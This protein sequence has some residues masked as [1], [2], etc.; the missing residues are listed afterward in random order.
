MRQF[1]TF[2]KKGLHFL[3]VSILL[4]VVSPCLKAQ[5]CTDPTNVIYAFS[6][7]G[8]LYPVNVTNMATSGIINSTPLNATTGANAIGYNPVNKLMYFFQNATTSGTQF[9]SYN[10]VGNIYT[11]LATPPIAGTVNRGC[12]SYNGTDYY[13]I[14]TKGNLFYYNIPTNTWTLITSNFTDQDGNNVTSVLQNEASGDMAID[15]A[16]DLWIVVSNSSKYG[17]YKL[18]AP[19]P[20]AAVASLTV[21]RLIDPSTLT[22]D[23]TNFVG[24]AFDA[25]GDIFMATNNDL[26]LLKLNFSVLHI[27]AFSTPGMCGDLTSCNFPYNILPVTFSDFSLR[28]NNNVVTLRWQT[29]G[30]ENAKG[31]YIERSDNGVDWSERGFVSSMNNGKTSNYS[32]I[33]NIVSGGKIYYRIKLVDNTGKITYSPVKTIDT[34]ASVQAN[35]SIGP[36][37]TSDKLNIS[38]DNNETV[39][40]YNTQGL[41]M[42]NEKLHAGINSIDIH[43]LPSGVYIVSLN[44]TA[45]NTAV[46]KIVKM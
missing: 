32:Y 24:I 30:N 6:N 29:S 19:L 36:N 46:K 1:Y 39:K 40:I 45:G 25:I 15:G 3:W 12:V 10:P 43:S 44:N 7:S 13:C 26:Y 17:L 35:I 20:N 34:G 18:S 14:D 38:I 21:K 8:N 33:D 27:G 9:V 42:H 28:Q 23:G 37:P 11:T 22:P 31:F 5:F 41:L 16:G 4:I 2:T